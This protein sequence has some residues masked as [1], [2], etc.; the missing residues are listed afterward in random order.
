METNMI[1]VVNPITRKATILHY[2]NECLYVRELH[3]G[4]LDEW[5]GFETDR[6]YAVHFDYDEMFRIC[7]Y[8]DATDEEYH[9]L[10]NVDFLVNIE[11]NDEDYNLE[12]SFSTLKLQGNEQ[13]QES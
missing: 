5:N 7:I 3:Y 9:G 8:E 2:V 4:E 13:T 6:A 10:Q 12:V 11:Y 1:A